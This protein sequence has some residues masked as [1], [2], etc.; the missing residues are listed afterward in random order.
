MRRIWI[1][2]AAMTILS[3]APVFAGQNGDKSTSPAD[4]TA[5]SKDKK[6]NNA[7]TS[8]S[9]SS[10]MAIQKPVIDAEAGNGAAANPSGTSN[11]VAPAPA[12]TAQMDQGNESPLYFKIG[13]AEFTPLGFMDFTS[14]YRSTDVGS[15]IGTNFNSIPF[16]GLSPVG[17]L[18]ELRFSAQNSRVGIRVDANPGDFKVRGYLE[19]DFLGNAAAN[20]Q[21][22]SH[23]DT[24]RM[25]LY[26]VDVQRGKWEVMAGQS[27]S[28]MTPNR[29]GISPMPGDIFFSQDMDTNYQ[30]GLVWLRT[31]GVRIVLHAN[32]HITWG[33]ALEDPE[34]FTG[35]LVTFPAGF[36]AAQV[37]DAGGNS[38]TPNKAPDVE[39]KL[40]FDSNPKGKDFHV[41]ISGIYRA[42]RLNTP[43]L[44]NVTK[45]GGGVSF[46]ANLA[47]AKNLH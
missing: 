24:L 43:G 23:S 1:L 39:S 21:I 2:V 33:F 22:G 10:S 44:G 11:S 16:N 17:P 32:D 29:V 14:V 45:S 38:K 8:K 27:W 26:W 5:T 46:N 9:E 31:P 25:R 34:Q 3:A 35:G 30:V 20:L 47:V 19:A 36:N 12:A 4:K 18:S 40:A 41:E 13:G 42:F 7:A 28:M 37:D 6:A 15:G